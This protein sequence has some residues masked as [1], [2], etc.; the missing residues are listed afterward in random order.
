[1]SNFL[2]L[3]RGGHEAYQGMSQQEKQAHMEVWGAWMENLRQQGKLIDGLPLSDEGKVVA[4]KGDVITDG[5][6]A[7]GAEMV[8]GYLIV[9][10]SDMEEA[11]S[12]SKSCPIFDYS[13]SH[14]EVREILSM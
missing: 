10:A 2:Y 9:N 6:Y 13:G 7:E 5:P 1:M 12:I 4:D 8:G 3:F 11:V 14:V